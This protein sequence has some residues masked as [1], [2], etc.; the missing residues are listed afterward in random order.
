MLADF[1]LLLSTSL[2]LF[3]WIVLSSPLAFDDWAVSVF[4]N[5]HP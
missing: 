2:I 1:L 4:P 3:P 5:A